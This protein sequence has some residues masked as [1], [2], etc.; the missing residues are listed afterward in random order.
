MTA[1]TSASSAIGRV[2]HPEWG[3]TWWG[4]ASPDSMRASVDGHSVIEHY[5]HGRLVIPAT[6]GQHLLIVTASDYQELK[7]MEDVAKIKPNTAT[8]TR[9]VVVR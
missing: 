1:A 5:R 8:L 4:R 9:T 7:N 3:R 2:T 6:S